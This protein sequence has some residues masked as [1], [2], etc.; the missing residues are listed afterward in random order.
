MADKQNDSTK[1]A[2]ILQEMGYI[3]G[4]VSDIKKNINEQF[5]TKTEYTSLDARVKRVE[6]AVYGFISLVL[7][8]VLSAVV[9]GVIIK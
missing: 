6:Q 7:V 4:D 9:G 1:I 3:K 8:L 2:L 5:V